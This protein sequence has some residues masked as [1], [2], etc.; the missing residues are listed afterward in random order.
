MT[1]YNKVKKA[2]NSYLHGANKNTGK[3]KRVNF[4]N[5]VNRS[6]TKKIDYDDIDD[7]CFIADTED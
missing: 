3:L 7:A 6:N 2:K 5:K 4:F 1:S